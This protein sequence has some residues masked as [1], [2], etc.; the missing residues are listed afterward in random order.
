[1]KIVF[2]ASECGP[3][4]KTG[5]LGD[6]IG[7]LPPELARGGDEISVFVPYYK[8]I[9]EKYE[10]EL[11]YICCFDVYLSW[12]KLYCGIFKKQ[13]SDNF[14]V[15]FVDNEYYFMRDECYGHPD[16]GERFAYFSK[17]VLEAFYHLDM[18][19]DAVHCHD[20]QTA[21]I[22]LL[23][24]S[25]Y[26]LIDRY[27]K[28]KTVLSI[29]NVEYQGKA[30]LNFVTDVL[31]I[32]AQWN[33]VCEFDG[34][35]NGL[36]SGI[37]LCD[38]LSTVSPTYAFEL[39]HAYFAHGLAEIISENSY[40]MTGILNGIDENVGPASDEYLYKKYRAGRYK[41]KLENKAFLQ[42]TLGLRVDEN[43]PVVGMISRLVTHKG[44]ELLER[45]GDEIA[46]R[47]IQLVILGT[48]DAR[49]ENFFRQLAAR[50]PGMVS[51]NI[52]FSNELASRVYAGSDF[53]LMP[54]K[55]EPCGLSQMIAMKY[56]T[57]PI[58]RETGGLFDTVYPYNP[59]TGEGR[60][61]TFKI[62]NAHDMLDAVVRAAELYRDKNKMKA[63][64]KNIMS[65]DFGWK[66]AAEEYKKLY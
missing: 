33:S 42:E 16:D 26:G 54:S 14:N 23:L 24:K 8:K 50:H 65:I 63:L 60:G 47:G 40:K 7:A 34:L 55:S 58:V 53:L 64:V 5:G 18:N 39:R 62:F 6:V 43:I 17:A 57:V 35:F 31:G 11:E 59:E 13:I 51:A 19:P 44:L 32:S 15:Y 52:T 21:T 22:P 46:G 45:V 48:G 2:A 12:R 30:D 4:I 9:K 20:W 56:G 41:T 37:V 61:L 29:H 25:T 3:F 10:S 66:N 49:F 36:K 1:M 27:A 38:K 28:I